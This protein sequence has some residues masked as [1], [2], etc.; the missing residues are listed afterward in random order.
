MKKPRDV[1]QPRRG[2]SGLRKKAE[3][4]GTVEAGSDSTEYRRYAQMCIE[5]AETAPS[6]GDRKAF[7]SLARQWLERASEAEGHAA[8]A[9][10][11]STGPM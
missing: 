5:Q 9:P 2:V 10:D 7:L 8:S 6:A 1:I 4:I 3:R 11:Q